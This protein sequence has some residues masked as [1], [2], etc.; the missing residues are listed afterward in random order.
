MSISIIRHFISKSS[1]DALLA[2]CVVNASTFTMSRLLK[3]RILARDVAGCIYRALRDQLLALYYCIRNSGDHKHIHIHL[4]TIS[5]LCHLLSITKGAEC[6]WSKLL[7]LVNSKLSYYQSFTD[8]E[9]VRRLSSTQARYVYISKQ[10]GNDFIE[11]FGKL[12]GV[13]ALCERSN[14]DVDISTI[15]NIRQQCEFVYDS[16]C[17]SFDE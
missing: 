6:P 1:Q 12:L 10:Q 2:L 4:T 17:V 16:V 7:C 3:D 13:L 14:P 9:L 8:L 11:L 15:Q 5:L